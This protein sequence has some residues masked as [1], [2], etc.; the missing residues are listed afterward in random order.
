ML[1]DGV[2]HWPFSSDPSLWALGL[3]ANVF[4]ELIRIGHV[5]TLRLLLL[6]RGWNAFC[7]FRILT[8]SRANHF[9]LGRVL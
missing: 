5:F 7:C 3:V 4:I 1:Y 8:R 2:N 6:Q 9:Y